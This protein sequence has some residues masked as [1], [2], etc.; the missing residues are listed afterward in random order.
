MPAPPRDTLLRVTWCRSTCQHLSLQF[1]FRN[2]VCALGERLPQTHWPSTTIYNSRGLI[3]F[4]MGF[5][6][7]ECRDLPQQGG[8]GAGPLLMLHCWQRASSMSWGPLEVGC[9]CLPMV[10]GAKNPYLYETDKAA[11]SRGRYP[12]QRQAA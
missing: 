3:P 8:A 7:C 9:P 10:E 2:P 11:A 12:G 4:Y 1:L 5:I 6:P